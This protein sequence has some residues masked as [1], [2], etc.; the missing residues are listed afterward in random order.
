MLACLYCCYL[1]D[2]THIFNK[3]LKLYNSQDFWMFCAAFALTGFS[4]ISRSGSPFRPTQ[5]KVE[6]SDQPFLSRDQTDEWKGWMQALILAYHYVGGSKVL[7]I[8]RIVRLLVASYLFMTGY[9]H[10]AYFYQRN[11]YSFKRVIAVL[12][13]LNLLSCLL[14]WMM[15][16]DY[17]FY[18]FAPLVTYWYIVIYITFRAQSEWNKNLTF[19]LSKVCVASM[20]TTVLHLQHWLFDPPMRLINF[21]FRSQ[22]EAEEWLFRVSLDQYVVYIG[23]VVAVLYIR[24]TRPLSPVVYPQSKFSAKSHTRSSHSSPYLKTS[25]S[26][27][28][29]VAALVVY[30]L[31]ANTRKSKESSNQLH[32]YISPLPILAFVYLRNCTSRLRNHHSAAFAWLGRISLETFVLQYHLWLAADTKGLLSLGILGDGG[33]G[34]ISHFPGLPLLGPGMGLARWTDCILLGVVFIWVSFKVSAATGAIT[35][36]AAKALFR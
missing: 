26:F 9:G 27:A 3:V 7:W 35:A 21:I 16:T 10:A 20:I 32:P 17:L 22:W 14:P 12:I 2:R 29:S 34:T 8:Y 30:Q 31:L 5:D 4:S 36:V 13:R 1:T 28:A 15:D 25:L 11:D 6:R 33:M 19:L 23:M 24:S 18:Y